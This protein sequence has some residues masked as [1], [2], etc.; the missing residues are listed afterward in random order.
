MGFEPSERVKVQA[1]IDRLFEV[2]ANIVDA[3]LEMMTTDHL[4]S[5]TDDL[6][7]GSPQKDSTFTPRKYEHAMQEAQ[8][9]LADVP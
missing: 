6:V 5:D 8:A 3:P 1:E 4:P 7:R 2:H 9:V